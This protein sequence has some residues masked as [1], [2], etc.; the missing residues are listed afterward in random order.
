MPIQFNSTDRMFILSGHSS[1]YA[2]HILNGGEIGHFFWGGTL[3]ENYQEEL[4]KPLLARGYYPQHRPG[5]SLDVLPQE[6]SLPDNGDFRTPAYE[7]ISSAG[8]FSSMLQYKDHRVV[9]GKPSLPGLPAVYVNDDSEADTL[10]I[11]AQD[12]VLNLNVILQYTVFSQLNVIVRSVRFEN[13]GTDPVRLN[14][15]MSCSVDFSSTDFQLLHLTGGWASERH[16]TVEPL[17]CGT[18]ILQSRK[19][20]S[21][22]R[23]NPFFALLDP[24][25]TETSGAVYA[26]NLVYSGSFSGEIEVI[27]SGLLRA[28]IGINPYV[29]DWTLQPGEGFQTPEAVMVYSSSGLGEMSRTFHRLY[30]NNLCRGHYKSK[31]RPILVN[32]WEAMYFK[33]KS[34][35]IIKLAGIAQKV[36]IELTVLDDGWFGKRNDTT[37]S[38]GDWFVDKEKIPEGIDGLAQQIHRIGTGF[39]LWV[40]PEMISVESE[41]YTKHPDWCIHIPERPLKFGRNQLVLDLSRT[42]IQDYVVDVLSEVFSC[43]LINYVKWDMNRS[44]FNLGS[45]GSCPPGELSHRYVLG[46][47]AV[48]ER[49]TAAFPDILFESCCGGGGR[50]DPGMLYYM[51]QVWTSDNTDAISR[52][53]IQKGTALVYPP[54]TMCAHVSSVPNHQTGRVTSLKLRRDVAMSGNFGYELDLC[55]SN[56]DELKDIARQVKFYKQIR[57]VITAGDMYRLIDI[58][59]KNSSAVQYISADRKTVIVFYYNLSGESRKLLLQA[60]DSTADYFIEKDQSSFSGG[61]LMEQGI[62]I[63]LENNQQSAVIVFRK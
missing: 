17:N 18:K 49:I 47:Y 15:A 19:G 42:E 43:G 1:V 44:L 38:L 27:P 22:H 5:I 31:E 26:F 46:L 14:K 60:L 21:S 39:G 13:S 30:R 8:Y 3:P 28:Q 24:H 50:Y 25:V 55:K 61:V 54:V 53:E 34:D 48:L 63:P 45:S 12:A 56:E 57:P 9:S 51:P 32:S 2:I 29:F 36:G 40:E 37:S 4:K 35:D 11:Y 33:F 23:Q 6:Y 52:L 16:I 20:Q 10:F 59:E 62:N 41:L 58:R 7:I